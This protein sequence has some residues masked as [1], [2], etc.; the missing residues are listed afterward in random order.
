MHE[1]LKKIPILLS[2]LFLHKITILTDIIDKH[3]SKKIWRFFERMLISF[4]KPNF[5]FFK[6]QN[7]D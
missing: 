1:I 7:P 5:V 3:F 4:V 6:V 2:F